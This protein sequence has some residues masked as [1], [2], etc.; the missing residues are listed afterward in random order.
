MNRLMAV[1]LIKS[2]SC[3]PQRR[4]NLCFPMIMNHRLTDSILH[5]K[6]LL[7]ISS[8]CPSAEKN[9]HPPQNHSFQRKL[10]RNSSF[11][12]SLSDCLKHAS[13]SGSAHP[14]SRQTAKPFSGTLP[15]KCK[16]CHHKACPCPGSCCCPKARLSRKPDYC[17]CTGPERSHTGCCC[18]PQSPSWSHFPVFRANSKKL[19]D[20]QKQQKVHEKIHSKIHIQI[21]YCSHIRLPPP[22]L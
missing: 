7:Q 21:Q 11:S 16:S 13:C 2:I 4:Q 20:Q 17:L 8:P 15:S 18:Q 6:S 19:S 5:P 1:G 14:Q 3:I 12:H 22:A 9:P 10:A